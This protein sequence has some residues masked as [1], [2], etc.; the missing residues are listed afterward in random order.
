MVRLQGFLTRNGY[1]H[2]LLDPAEDSDARALIE[3]YAPQPT[4]MPLAVC[5]DGSVLKNPSENQLAQCLGMRRTDSPH[6]VFDVAIVGAGPAGLAAAVYAASEGLSTIVFDSMHSAGRRRQ[7]LA[8]RIPESPDRHFRPSAGRAR[9]CPGAEIRRR[10]G[11]SRKRSRGLIARRRLSHWTLRGPPRAGATAIVASGARYRRPEFQAPGLRRPRC[12]VLGIAHRGPHVREE[13]IVLVGGGNSAGQAAV[14]LSGFASKVWM[15]VRGE[16]LA[17]S[18]S[19]YLIDRIAATPN[20]EVLLAPR[21]W[22][23]RAHR[24]AALSGCA[25]ASRSPARKPRSRSAMCSCSSVQTRRRIAQGLRR[26]TRQKRFRAHRALAFIEPDE[27]AMNARLPMLLKSNIFG[28]FAVGDVRCG[29]V[30]RVGGAIGE[31]AAVV[32]ELHS[33]L[34]GTPVA[35]QCGPEMPRRL[36]NALRASALRAAEARLG[37]VTEDRC[38]VRAR[39]CIAPRRSSVTVLDCLVDALTRVARPATGEQL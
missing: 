4:E 26:F 33:F 25:G 14:F 2:H 1:P 11:D 30:K 21:S 28:V 31:G 13:E 36:R 6:R 39:T 10:D 18:M 7:A 17:E 24:T 23:S 9:L 29:S 19:R 15:L 27:L 38:A 32:P 5:S 20:I 3:R 16:G 37:E 35:A 8:S 34:V 12:L 22:P